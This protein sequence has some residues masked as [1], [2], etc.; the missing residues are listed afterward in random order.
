M[1]AGRQGDFLPASL[2]F[3]MPVKAKAGVRQEPLAADWKVLLWTRHLLLIS[4]DNAAGAQHLHI[5]AGPVADH[6]L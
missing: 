6:L 5:D 1:S 2:V 4:I 3:L